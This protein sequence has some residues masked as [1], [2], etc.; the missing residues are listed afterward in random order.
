MKSTGLVAVSV[1]VLMFLLG[2]GIGR[3]THPMERGI[4]RAQRLMHLGTLAER[5]EA[6]DSLNSLKHFYDIATSYAKLEQTR[7]FMGAAFGE[8]LVR[9]Q[10]WYEAI[11]N[12][13]LARNI[14]PDDFSVNFSLASAYASLYNIEQTPTMKQKYYDLAVGSLNVALSRKPEDPDANYLMGMLLFLNGQASDAMKY[15]QATLKANPDHV[16]ALM[17]IARIYYDAGN[18]EAAKK[19][20][21][22]LESK[23]PASSTTFRIVQQNL[24]KINEAIGMQGN[25]Q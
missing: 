23:L 20:Y 15:F 10:M 4:R 19:I 18:I 3:T 12:L 2:F 21:L 9:N 25:G 5:R 14:M 22:S 1:G 7:Y 13:I 16:D 6:M 8:V 11:T 17:S 24:D